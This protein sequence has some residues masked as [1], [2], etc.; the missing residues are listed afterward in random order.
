MEVVSE[1][2]IHE[3]YDSDSP[4]GFT[5]IYDSTD[6]VGVTWE[7]DDGIRADDDVPWNYINRCQVVLSAFDNAVDWSSISPEIVR[8]EFEMDDDEVDEDEENADVVDGLGPEP[9]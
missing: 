4:S 2:V 9:S 3:N 5:V 1:D 7:A 8:A 6:L